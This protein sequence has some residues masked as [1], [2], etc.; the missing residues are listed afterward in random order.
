MTQQIFRFA[1]SPNGHLHL[2]HAYSAL[3]NM[4][5]AQQKGGRFLLRIEDTD[6]TRCT[7]AFTHQ[8]F[9]D[10]TW[11]GLTWEEPVRI[12]SQHFA[13]YDEA[14]HKLWAQGH[15]YP[16][17]CS[18]KAAAQH[19]RHTKDPD[20]T[21]HYGGTCRDLSHEEATQRMLSEQFG[22]RLKTE[23]TDAATWGDVIIAKPHVG[24]SYHIAVVVDDALQ[25]VT[26]V[27]RGK[28]M[29][30]A[31]PIHMLLQKQLN[32]P[33]PHYNHHDLIQDDAGQKLSKS[34]KS[35]SLKQMRKDGVTAHQI[36]TTLG[37]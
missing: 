2:G 33:T 6:A 30:A 8:I 4:Q 25:G 1:P 26:Q 34:L 31:T 7:E 10:L 23:E 32:L 29:E 20:G 22:W 37:F 11:L 27:V 18:R 15:V 24:S 16:C 5:M 19:A 17:F 12:Q 9:E 3:L 21:P 14:L 36:K 35:R 13:D 28:D